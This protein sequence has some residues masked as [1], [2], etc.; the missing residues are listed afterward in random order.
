[1]LLVNGAIGQHFEVNQYLSNQGISFSKAAGIAQDTLGFVWFSNEQGLIRFDGLH[2]QI[3]KRPLFEHIRSLSNSNGNLLLATDSLLVRIDSRTDTAF[4]DI[5]MTRDEMKPNGL[6]EADIFVD[7]QGMVWAGNSAVILNRKAGHQQKMYD[8][9]QTSK[10]ASAKE[11]CFFSEDEYGRLWALTGTGKLYLYQTKADRFVMRARLETTDIRYFGYVG[12]NRLRCFGT[13]QIEVELNPLGNVIAISKKKIKTPILASVS[14]VSD[15]Y[16]STTDGELY[17]W[18]FGTGENTEVKKLYKRNISQNIEDLPIQKVNDLYETKEGELWVSSGNGIYF[19]ERLFFSSLEYLPYYAIRAMV[20]TKDNE[21]YI[22]TGELF[23]YGY[24]NGELK[25]EDA[26]VNF[27]INQFGFISSM[28]ELNDNL[29]MGNQLGEL[30]FINPKGTGKVKLPTDG[31]SIFYLFIDTYENLWACQAPDKTPLIGLSKITS[32]HQV[33]FYGKEK[34]IENRVLVVDTLK[35]GSLFAAGVGVDSYLY[36]YNRSKDL[37]E[38]ISVPLGIENAY[39]FEV[40]DIAPVSRDEVWLG[41]THGLFHYAFGNIEK[42]EF[43]GKHQNIEIRAVEVTDSGVIWAST[44]IHGLICIVDDEMVFFDERSGLPTKIMNYRKLMIDDQGYLWVGTDQGAVISSFNQPRLD[45]T[46]K[47]KLV[48]V[49]ASDKDGLK[50]KNLTDGIT[51]KSDILFNYHTNSYPMENI[52]YQTRVKGLNEDWSFPSA[53]NQLE[54]QRMAVGRYQFQVRAMNKKGTSWSEVLSHDFKVI[55]IWYNRPWAYV[56]YFMAFLIAVMIGVRLYAFHLKVRNKTLE[57]TI[58]QRTSKILS[59]QAIIENQNLKL[60]QTNNQ[61]EDAV[62]RRTRELKVANE[63]LYEK[64]EELDL[65][66]YRSAHDLRG[67][68]TTMM[69]LCSL[70]KNDSEKENLGLYFRM[71]N[72][73]ANKMNQTVLRLLRT[74]KIKKQRLAYEDILIKK[75]IDE[76]ILEISKSRNLKHIDLKIAFNENEVVMSDPF[77]M[78]IHLSNVLDN[79][80]QYSDKEK[81]NSFVEVRAQRKNGQ[82]FEIS[83]IDNGQPVSHT[84]DDLSRMFYRG[85]DLSQGPGLGLYESKII[86]ERLSGEMRLDLFE[87][88]QKAFVTTIPVN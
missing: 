30:H 84:V 45:Q 40:H 35:D 44:D 3:Y 11:A 64:K 2:H 31:G 17:S 21:F 58:T 33:E 27:S 86:V 20:K 65:F 14:I 28:V 25:K 47:P 36:L 80:F 69:G 76:I 55:P 4:F 68:I 16:F 85:S 39:G 10:Q 29:W 77:L 50:F 60:L 1:M 13:A 43:S 87:D 62:L 5:L 6:H 32:D 53:E 18:K 22:S 72:Q 54:L 67:P 34:G 61:L 56:A 71:M 8:L 59:Q 41:T 70:G 42:I 38:N 78:N 46:I 57:R 63:D 74:H 52:L 81:D 7:S 24:D 83:V 12:R 37:F 66:I 73:T 26:Q 48:S 79:A 23:K 75:M 19:L 51:E 15:H 82:R 88:G 9:P 49:A